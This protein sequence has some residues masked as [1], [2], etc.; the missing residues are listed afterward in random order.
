M[1]IVK[2]CLEMSRS[3]TPSFL[4]RLKAPC[5]YSKETSSF[6]FSHCITKGSNHAGYSG[7]AP[8]Y[9]GTSLT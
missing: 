2:Y 4:S 7:T 8:L 3:L 1:A 6:S 5:R 9:G